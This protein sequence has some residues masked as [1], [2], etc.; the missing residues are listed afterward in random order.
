MRFLR[1]LVKRV[2]KRIP[3]KGDERSGGKRDRKGIVKEKKIVITWKQKKETTSRT[4]QF[5]FRNYSSFGN[6]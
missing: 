5:S 1:I 4:R 6:V 2:K 3:K